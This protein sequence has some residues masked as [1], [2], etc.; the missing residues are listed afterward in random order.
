M[1]SDKSL[2]LFEAANQAKKLRKEIN[3]HSHRYYALDNPEIPD[4]AF[5]ALLHRL[6]ELETTFPELITPDSPTQRV[7]GSPS[8]AFARVAHLTPMRSLGNAFSGEDLRAFDNR[9]RTALGKDSIEYVVELKIDGLAINLTY[10]DGRLI[11][12]ATRGDGAEG[13][14]VTTNIRTIRSVP[15]ALAENGKEVPKLLEVRGEVYM[16]RRE[17]E[18]LNSER[19][20]VGEPLMA[21]PRNAAAGSI[22]QLD[23][24][25]TAKRALDVFIYGIGVRSN[26]DFETHA[27]MLEYLKEIGFKINSRYQ[28][29]DDINQVIAYCSSWTETRKE[30]PYDIDGMVVK[31][32]N[33]EDQEALGATAKDPRWAI[34]YKFPAEQAT[35]V[36]EDIFVGVGR[37]GTLTPTA[38]LKPVRLAGS[39][40]SRA[41]LHNEDYVKEKDI[42]VGD[43]VIIHKAG[44]VIPEVVSVVKENR[45]GG[46]QPFV[47]P[48]KCPECGSK[49][50]RRE[51][52]AAYK[53]INN[54]CP[55]LQREGLIHFVARDAMNIEGLGPSVLTSLLEAGLVTDVA[56]L[57]KLTEEKLLELERIGPKS[58]QNLINAIEASKQ[59]GLSRV[60][61]GL[62]IRYVGVKAAGTIARHFGDVDK[63]I[64]SNFDEL[65]QLEDIGEKIAESIVAHFAMPENIDLIEKLKQAGVK[66]TEDM[67]L[68]AEGQ[69]LS[70]NTFVLTGTLSQLTRSEAAKLI[71]SMGGKV[72]GSVSKK[73]SFVVA[74]DE[75]GSKLEKAQQLGVPVLSEDEFI[76]MTKV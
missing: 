10:Q 72:A 52:E 61:F 29:F 65:I 36:V 39:V 50:V 19:E 55:A 43:T 11:R 23:P 62:G 42:R 45:N 64:N 46:E 18:R 30:L 48:D 17:F 4:A 66:L 51:G 38:I 9:V 22:R 35:T 32:N 54:K 33:I 40:I 2:S 71:E 15:L 37:T 76:N 75:A 53:C 74:G 21:N 20:S 3:Y 1:K 67:P 41:T 27:D 57:Y 63:I 44:D 56:D 58:A 73:T 8:E 68:M 6:I 47:M 13:E 25:I 26:A 69:P 28:V 16:P 34:A 60:L 59:A 12:G 5:D 7:G 24:R 14:D 70:G 31:V 49:A